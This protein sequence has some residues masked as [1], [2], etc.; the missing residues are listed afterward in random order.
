MID[1]DFVLRLTPLNA[2]NEENVLE[3]DPQRVLGWLGYESGTMIFIDGPQGHSNFSVQE[4]IKAIRD[5]IRV[6]RTSHNE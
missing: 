4:D 2:K 6:L 3:L 1:P 5:Q